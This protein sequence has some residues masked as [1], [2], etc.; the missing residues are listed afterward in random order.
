MP[1][2]KTNKFFVALD[3]DGDREGSIYQTK[4]EAIEYAREHINSFYG[5][6]AYVAEVVCQIKPLGTPI[7]VIDL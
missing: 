1:E 2:T 5:K 6:E 3:K 4:G 7:Q